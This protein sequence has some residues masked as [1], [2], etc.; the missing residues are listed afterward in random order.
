MNVLDFF[1]QFVSP[2]GD[3]GECEYRDKDVKCLCVGIGVLA[4]RRVRMRDPFKYR[5]AS[6]VLAR[7][8]LRLGVSVGVPAGIHG[9]YKTCTWIGILVGIHGRCRVCVGVGKP[10]AGYLEDA[11]SGCFPHLD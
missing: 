7:K 8:I 5:D 10:L 1:R 4:A 2:D 11:V 6:S 3:P 9:G